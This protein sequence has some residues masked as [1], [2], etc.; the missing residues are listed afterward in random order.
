[1]LV[2]TLLFNF[3]NNTVIIH[4]TVKRGLSPFV[5]FCISKIYLMMADLDSQNMLY[6]IMNDYCIR[7]VFSV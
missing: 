4:N 3:W 1:M 7:S 5:F 2:L 6:Y